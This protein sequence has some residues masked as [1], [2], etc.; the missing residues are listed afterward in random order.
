M[1]A[2]YPEVPQMGYSFFAVLLDELERSA[3]KQAKK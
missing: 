2:G 1:M 3:K